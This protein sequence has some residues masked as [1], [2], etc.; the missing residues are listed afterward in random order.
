MNKRNK[1]RDLNIPIA[2]I[3][4]FVVTGKLYRSN[5]RF[6]NSY[7]SF[8]QAMMINLWN[9]SVWAIINGKRKLIKR[10]LN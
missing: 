9:G 1:I 10:V 4:K 8:N 6:S 5:K 2:Q 3:E 7:D